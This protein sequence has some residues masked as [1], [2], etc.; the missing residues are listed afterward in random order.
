MYD[1]AGENELNLEALRA[2][3]KR[4]SDTE[5]APL[6]EVRTLH[7]LARGQSRQTAAPGARNIIEGSG[8]GMAAASPG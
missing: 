1:L 6:R 5:T 7:V 3:L 4:M 8:G 2:R